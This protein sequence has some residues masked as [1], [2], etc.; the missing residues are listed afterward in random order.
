[1]AQFSASTGSAER[2]IRSICAVFR[3]FPSFHTNWTLCRH[4]AFAAGSRFLDAQLISSHRRLQRGIR[5][6]FILPYFGYSCA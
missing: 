3:Q 4:S 5:F 2:K 6:A 1:V